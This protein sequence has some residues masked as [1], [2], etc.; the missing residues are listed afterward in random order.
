MFKVDNERC[1]GCGACVEV[2]PVQAISMNGGK[3]NIDADRCVNCGRC[4]QVCPQE[5]LYP[6]IRA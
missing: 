3:A 2:C 1:V 5:A 4:A 6:G